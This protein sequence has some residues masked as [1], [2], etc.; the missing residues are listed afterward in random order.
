MREAAGIPGYQLAPD[1]ELVF[2]TP[3]NGFSHF[4][5]YYDKS[6]LDASGSRLL[7]HRVAFDARDIEAGDTADVGFWSVDSEVFT[8]LGTTRTFNW[9]QG[10]MLQWLPPDFASR[11]IYNDLRNN[12][13]V[14]VIVDTA[15]G[16][17]NVI[18][19]PVYAVHPSGKFALCA[20]Y[21]RLRYCRPGY[22][23]LGVDR[24]EWDRPLHPDDGIF[25][26]DLTT[27][28]LERI[29]RTPD[30]V[31]L[32]PRRDFEGAS[33][34]LEHMMWNPSGTRF[35]FFH[36]WERPGAGH[37]TR[38]LTA[39]P[40]GSGVHL[41]PDSGFYSH[42]G[43]R[44]D[45]EFTI[46]ALEGSRQ[47]QRTIAVRANPFAKALLRPPYRLYKR[48]TGRAGQETLLPTAVYLEMTDG[49]DKSGPLCPRQLTENGHNTWSSD[50]RWMLTDTYQDTASNRQLLLYD[51]KD[52]I[53][54]PLGAF[55]SPFND[56]GYRCD[57]HPRW[58]RDESKVIVDSAHN[59]RTRQMVVLRIDRVMENAEAS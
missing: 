53:V 27:G 31:R 5:G 36:R 49:V 28:K 50:G 20:N 2:E 9:Q 34:W 1:A 40:D 22:N 38:L 18:P 10:S 42:M 13:F 30:L 39:G 59:G 21:E 3:E 29:I 17:E 25:R 41:F 55:H 7:C 58:S 46:F 32:R 52:D 4:F 12:A 45:R 33:H 23:Y 8:K 43:W 19:Y 35:A 37:K 54:I 44:T 26:L 14:S 24:S 51:R 47:V 11:V 6:P 48:L 15:S 56:C 57:L 16:R